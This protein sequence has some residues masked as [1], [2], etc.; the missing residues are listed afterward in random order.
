MLPIASPQQQDPR[1]LLVHAFCQ[2][3]CDRCEQRALLLEASKLLERHHGRSSADA[4]HPLGTQPY[5]IELAVDTPPPCLASDAAHADDSVVLSI[6]D[7]THAIAV[8][9]T[10]VPVRISDVSAFVDEDAHMVDG[11]LTCHVIRRQGGAMQPRSWLLPR[12]RL[13]VPR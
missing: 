3:R 1:A 8:A 13:E 11:F 9:E 2:L 12:S 6:A 5:P 7:A 4:T 10:T